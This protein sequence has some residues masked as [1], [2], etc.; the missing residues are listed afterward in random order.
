M[1]ALGGSVAGVANLPGRMVQMDCL[2][3]LI[4]I[5]D[6]LSVHVTDRWS[7][8][9]EPGGRSGLTLDLLIAQHLL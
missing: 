7:L 8:L 6:R 4:W 5:A 3:G 1:P 2:T 9:Q